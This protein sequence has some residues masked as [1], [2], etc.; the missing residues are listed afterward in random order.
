MLP[1]NM[2]YVLKRIFEFMS[3]LVRFFSFSVMVDFV[4]YLRDAFRTQEIFEPE[5]LIRKRKP[6]IPENQMARD[7][8]S[9]NQ[10]CYGD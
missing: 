10:K 7:I 6:V 8:E 3:F 4:F 5:N 2:L 1:Q 9:K